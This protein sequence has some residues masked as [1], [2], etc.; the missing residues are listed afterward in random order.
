MSVVILLTELSCSVLLLHIPINYIPVCAINKF[1]CT[2]ARASSHSGLHMLTDHGD[3]DSVVSS[4]VTF[5]DTVTVHLHSQCSGAC[6]D[7]QETAEV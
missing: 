3:S 6:S 2:C 7:V 4:P 5:V 1:F